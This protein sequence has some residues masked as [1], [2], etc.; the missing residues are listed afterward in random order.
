MSSTLLHPFPHPYLTPQ[1]TWLIPKLHNSGVSW[2][3]LVNNIWSMG[4]IRNWQEVISGFSLHQATKNLGSGPW[5]CYLFVNRQ[6]QHHHS[7]AQ[8]LCFTHSLNI[9]MLYNIYFSMSIK[10]NY[11]YSHQDRD[12]YSI[13]FLNN[14]KILRNLRCSSL[15][16]QC[17]L[18]RCVHRGPVH[19]SLFFL[20]VPF[21]YISSLYIS[22]NG[23]ILIIHL[24][25]SVMNPFHLPLCPP[26]WG[27]VL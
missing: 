23:F 6:L 13:H 4:K 24:F 3:V 1:K 26:A 15:F 21:S 18:A 17:T 20:T 22:L 5:V 19:P 25:I 9:N 16:L 12:M 27:C 2:L 11:P 10:K 8:K 14:I 7:T